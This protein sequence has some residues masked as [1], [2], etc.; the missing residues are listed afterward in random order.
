[1][2]VWPSV[3]VDTIATVNGTLKDH[4]E[5][6]KN[7]V[8]AYVPQDVSAVLL[9]E[10]SEIPGFFDW[11]RNRGLASW[12]SSMQSMRFF[13]ELTKKAGIQ[14]G[15]LENWGYQD[16]DAFNHIYPSFDVMQNLLT[17]GSRLLEAAAEEVAQDNRIH[18]VPV[19]EVFRR[20][21]ERDAT[22]FKELYSSQQSSG[23]RKF[24][25]ESG[26]WL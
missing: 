13:A 10:Q 4:M 12:D 3:K 6:A 23:H 20:V 11:S 15:L 9:Q 24:L 21:L 7:N 25:S 16:G 14:L 19:G 22:A 17:K 2:G 18:V 5:A 26:K 1:M 8:A